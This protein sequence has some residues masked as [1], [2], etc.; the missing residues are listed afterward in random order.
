MKHMHIRLTLLAALLACTVFALS[1]CGSGTTASQEE[2]SQPTVDTEAP[3]DPSTTPEEDAETPAGSDASLE[4]LLGADYADYILETVTMQ[5]ENRMD[6]DPEVVFFPVEENKPLTDY[7]ALD[8]TLSYTADENGDV[9]ITFPAGTVAD[10]SF[11]DQ[12]FTLPNPNP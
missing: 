3:A 10:E 6:K 1:A 2:S 7:V 4:D 9:T 11:G 5:M 8:D 12:S